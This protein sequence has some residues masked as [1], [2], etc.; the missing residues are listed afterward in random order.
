MVGQVRIPHRA[1]D[2]DLRRPARSLASDARRRFRRDRNAMLGLAVLAV[3]AL[4]VIVGP[5]F[6]PRPVDEID[7]ARKL[8][9]PDLVHLM[10]TD[11]VGRD[12][13][14]RILSGGRVTLAVGLISAAVALT[15]GT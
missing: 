15:L 4:V 7:I 6:Y 14:A 12:M 1:A 3:I 11:N 13:L 5:V 10:G 2:A 9:P 8:R